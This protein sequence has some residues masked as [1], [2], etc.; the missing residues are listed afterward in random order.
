MGRGASGGK[1]RSKTSWASV[2]FVI[3]SRVS[4]AHS[5]GRRPYRERNQE[6]GETRSVSRLEG[7]SRRL[8]PFSSDR[9]SSPRFGSRISNARGGTGA[10]GVARASPSARDRC[11][12]RWS[13]K[14]RSS[15]VSTLLKRRVMKAVVPHR[16]ISSPSGSRS[17]E[18]KTARSLADPSCRSKS[19]R[20]R[21]IRSCAVSRAY[22]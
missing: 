6:R 7:V 16:A 13:V 19:A 15:G 4:G 12:S 3:G 1:S 11:D 20:R 8:L 14:T 22:P 9:R 17:G 21:A 18:R 2:P 5:S 10:Q